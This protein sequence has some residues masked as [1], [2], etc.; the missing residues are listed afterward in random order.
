MRC[1]RLQ[2]NMWSD[3]S[4]ATFYARCAECAPQGTLNDAGAKAKWRLT[5]PVRFETPDYL[6]FPASVVSEQRRVYTCVD[7]K[8][9]SWLMFQP[10][11]V[12]DGPSSGADSS[13]T[14]VAALSH[15]GVYTLLRQQRLQP[16]QQFRKLADRWYGDLLRQ[17]AAGE[18]WA[19]MCYRGLR[20]FGATAAL[21]RWK[22]MF[23]HWDLASAVLAIGGW[24]LVRCLFDAN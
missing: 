9:C 21:T 19:V 6:A 10:G 15:D 22:K 8:G 24:L 4:G 12:W 3:L 11:Y 17:F 16:W 13:T 5:N 14:C 18:L 7:Q 23:V 1:Q 2:D 20:V